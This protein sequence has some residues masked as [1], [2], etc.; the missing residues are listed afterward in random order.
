MEV[1]TYFLGTPFWCGFQRNA[2]RKKYMDWVRRFNEGRA[3]GGL[4]AAYPAV[5]LLNLELPWWLEEES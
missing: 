3:K 4:V 5:I 1:V 2:K